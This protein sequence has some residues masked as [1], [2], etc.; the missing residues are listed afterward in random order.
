MKHD[1]FGVSLIGCIIFCCMIACVDGI[2]GIITAIGIFV[3]F[4]LYSLKQEINANIQIENQNLKETNFEKNEWCILNDYEKTILFSRLQKYFWDT[5]PGK[6]KYNASDYTDAVRYITS[7]YKKYELKELVWKL[8]LEHPDII[9]LELWT[10]VY[11]YISEQ[12]W[13]E[14]ENNNNKIITILNSIERKKGVAPWKD[15]WNIN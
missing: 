1:G 13:K 12:Y 15:D 9:K 10:T 11:Q 4:L 14:V 5:E 2:L 6:I 8:H 3:F 7:G